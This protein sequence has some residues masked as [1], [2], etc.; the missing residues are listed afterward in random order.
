MRSTALCALPLPSPHGPHRM[1]PCAC[2]PQHGC[3]DKSAL[4]LGS[5]VSCYEAGFHEMLCIG[6]AT[7]DAAC[8]AKADIDLTKYD[9]CRSDA[10]VLR[11]VQ[12]DISQRG[13]KVHSFPKVTIGGKL[14]SN[15]AQD[16]KTLKESL[17]KGG[18]QAA[19]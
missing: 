16:P 12:R 2:A 1:A 13:A 9:A 6:A 19:C 3:S 14:A 17:C 7:K 10:S 15:A 5:F 4:A 11:Q 18:V 8:I